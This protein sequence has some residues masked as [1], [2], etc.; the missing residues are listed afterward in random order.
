MNNFLKCLKQDINRGIFSLTFLC[1]VVFMILLLWGSCISEYILGFNSNMGDV[2]YY[3]WVAHWQGF[4]II[5]LIV[6]SIGSIMLCAEFNT[7]YIRYIVIRS[8]SHDYSLSKSIACV[9]IGAF[10]V[11]L[12]E[13]VFIATLNLFSPI[14]IPN[15]PVRIGLENIEPFGIF[16][17]EGKYYTYLAVQILLI[18]VK[19][20]VFASISVMCAAFTSN[21]F[22]SLSIP[23]TFYYF[24]IVISRFIPTLDINRFFKG[25]YFKTPQTSI[26]FTVS[27]SLMIIF[28]ISG[29][30]VCKIKRRLQNE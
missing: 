27:I 1:S 16:L 6:S 4:S 20:A 28:I 26:L 8:S 12:S 5:T 2:M 7:K 15:N 19:S 22:M 21:I 13:I 29:L 10:A 25:E 18:T 14:A 3:Y 30:S 17:K 9:F 23:V 24:L 11:M